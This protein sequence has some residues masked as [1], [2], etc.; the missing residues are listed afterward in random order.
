MGALGG[1][2][3][4]SLVCVPQVWWAQHLACPF[5]AVGSVHG[6]E[7]IGAAVA[8]IARVALMLP[9]L[10]YVDDYFGPSR[11]GAVVVRGVC[12]RLLPFGVVRVC[13]CIGRERWSM[14]CA[15][16]RGSSVSC[17]GRVPWPT[18]SASSVGVSSCWA[19]TS[20][21][22]QRAI[23]SSLRQLRLACGVLL[24][25]IVV[26]VCTFVQVAKWL[27]TIEEA[28]AQDRLVPGGASKLA[29]KLY[30]GCSCAFK[31]FG[32]AMIRRVLILCVV[33]LCLWFVSNAVAGP[34]LTR[35]R[36]GTGRCVRNLGRRW[37]G[38][39][40][41]CALSSVSFGNGSGLTSL[42]FIFSSTRAAIH[43]TLGRFSIATGESGGRIWPLLWPCS[44]GSG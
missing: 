12:V 18:T 36:N 41:R 21:C 42:P 23:P 4:V 32:R 26:C 9:V 13:V 24:L 5:G 22:P 7:R 16:S 30:W 8:H 14:P 6:W 11:W 20:R 2:G 40:P 19:W 38:G 3:R 34:S 15:A 39:S 37:N 27:R 44:R 1:P 33:G 43:L 29:G 25:C 10:R 31:R 28:L 35:S 17:L